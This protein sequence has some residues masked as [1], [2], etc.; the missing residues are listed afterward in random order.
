MKHPKLQFYR[1]KITDTKLI[2]ACVTLLNEKYGAGSHYSKWI[3]GGFRPYNET[4]LQGQINN[5]MRQ[6][7]IFKTQQDQVL[8]MII[9][10][11]VI[12]PQSKE[13][14]MIFHKFC[15]NQ[16]VGSDLLSRAEKKAKQMKFSK[17]RVEIF[18][19]AIKLVNYYFDR[20]YD[21]LISYKQYENTNYAFMTL[22]KLN[23]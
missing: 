14:H 3:K 20:G 1:V 13:H 17:L 8:A 9:L 7:W 5:P 15:A 6:L 10:Q 11:K 18:T 4:Y 16:G 19:P 21:K 22:E 2:S 12:V 23:N